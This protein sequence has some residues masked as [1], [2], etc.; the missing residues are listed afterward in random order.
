MGN[1]ARVLILNPNFQQVKLTK[2]SQVASFE[3][4]NEESKPLR[5]YTGNNKIKAINLIAKLGMGE[6]T[7]GDKLSKQ[8]VE[9]LFAL[10][11]IHADAFS[12]NDEIGLCK[13]YKHKIELLPSAKPINEPL[14]RRAP[15][16][17]EETRRQVKDLLKK[18]IIEKSSSPWASAYVLAKKQNGEYRLCIDFRR[19]NDMTKKDVYPLPNIEDCLDTLSGKVYFSLID[20][21]AGFWQ[22]EVEEKSRELT[23]FKNEDGSYQFKRMP[24]GLTNAPASFQKTINSILNGLKGTNLQVFVDDV[25]VATPTWQEHI[26]LLSELLS[27]IIRSGL[28]I[29]PKKCKLAM[30]EIKFLGHVISQQGIAQD[31]EKLKAIEQLPEPRDVKGVRQALGLFSYYRKFVENFAMISEPLTRLT[32]KNIT[33]VWGTEQ[34]AAF[35]NIINKLREN[36]ILGHFNH[37]DPVQLKTDASRSGVAAILPQ[38]QKGEWIP[39]TCCSRRLSSSETNYGITD[40]E[41]LAIIYAVSKLRPYLLGKHFTIIVDHCALCALNSKQPAL[42]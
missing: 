20:F 5:S 42:N 27:I 21:K 12:F 17:V 6:M 4:Y 35:R 41:G 8:Q 30:H 38:R 13:T 7:F 33:F 36:L 24:F 19:L 26:E 16:Q 3:R 40:L 14:R 22:L 10:L 2:G 25:C 18:D 29:N 31:P 32:R 23:S 34:K 11:N 9:E 39:I 1:S 15:V 28:K 37:E